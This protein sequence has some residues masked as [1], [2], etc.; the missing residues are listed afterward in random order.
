MTLRW[1]KTE[2][3]RE[4]RAAQK[5]NGSAVYSAHHGDLRFEAK[6]V[7]RWGQSGWFLRAYNEKG[8][9]C[10]SVIRRSLKDCKARAQEFVETGRRF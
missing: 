3:V 8:R 2:S 1:Q 6:Q 10:M 7:M 5:L 4:G 9:C